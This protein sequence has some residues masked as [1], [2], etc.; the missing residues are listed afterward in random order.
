MVGAVLFVSVVI[1]AFSITHGSSGGKKA[2]AVKVAGNSIN[3]LHGQW[4][5][6][7]GASLK[8]DG[9]HVAHTGLSIVQQNG[10]GG[11]PNPPVNVYGTHLDF[12]GSF[13]LNAEF[14]NVRGTASLQLYGKPPVIQDE[15][16]VEPPS[17]RLD[18]ASGKLTVGV[19][20]G[21]ATRDLANQKPASSQTFSFALAAATKLQLIHKANLLTVMVNDKQLASITERGALKSGQIWFG[22]DA[23][24]VNGSWTLSKLSAQPLAGGSVKTVD[25]SATATAKIAQSAGGLQMLASKKRPG[26]LV[27]SAM[28]LTPAVV[29]AKYSAIAFGG[30][31]GAMT[32]EN[33]LK[34]QFVQPQPNLYTF[35][36]ADALVNL[37]RSHN[38]TIHGHALVFGEAN[39]SWVSHLPTTTTAD[40]NHVRDVMIDHIAKIVG[41]FKGH[42]ASWD[43]VNEPL[44][45]YSDTSDG[46]G[47]TLRQHI[48]ERALGQSYIPLAFR[49]A[50]QADPDAKLY[51]NDYG[52]ESDGDRWDALVRLVLRLKKE[53]VPIY[54]VGFESHVYEAEEQIDTSVLR[55]HIRQLAA[56]GL[57]SRIS[58]MDVYTDDDAAVQAVQYAQV[59]TACI[60]E[61]SCVSFTTWGFDDDYDMWQGDDHSLQHGKDLLWTAGATPTLA[62]TKVKE[63]LK[64]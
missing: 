4:S 37:A 53:G 30:N 6:L 45:D 48:W 50:H 24:G 7:L 39:P 55:Q 42:V 3:L 63:A 13:A 31:F 40:K 35:Q 2:P 43:A 23:P 19:W 51:L 10:S 27:G 56:L 33:A 22:A 28:S 12:S 1:L 38:L 5:Y 47:A 36:E 52:L 41:H 34:F 44:A 20:D 60:A 29:D 21:K 57:K 46:E 16:R 49:A 58:E 64:E 11:Q 32:V 25:T 9:L 17:I 54:G 26:F 18:I 62:L 61:P 14:S 59:M 8:P 15:F